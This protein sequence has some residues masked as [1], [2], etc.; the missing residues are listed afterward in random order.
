M[1]KNSAIFETIVKTIASFN[2]NLKLLILSTANNDTYKEIVSKYDIELLYEVFMDR[3]Y[4][5]EG[6][7][8]P[9]SQENAVIHNSTIALNRIKTLIKSGYLESVNGKKLEIE[10]DTICV[11]GDHEEAVEF[12]KLLRDIL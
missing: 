11:H 10:V 12:V 4:T 2:K 8:V 9:R 7:L 3:N 6:F 5:D 1:M